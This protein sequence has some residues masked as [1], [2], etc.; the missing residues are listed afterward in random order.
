MQ[1][2][3]VSPSQ[4]AQTSMPLNEKASMIESPLSQRQGIQ[5]MRTI[6]PNSPSYCIQN[7]SKQQ[8]PLQHRLASPSQSA[9]VS[10]PSDP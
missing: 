7:Q 10:M 5:Q 6:S 1:H 2:G 8:I 4:S 9:Q 3:V